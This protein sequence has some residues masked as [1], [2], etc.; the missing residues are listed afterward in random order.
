MDIGLLKNGILIRAAEC[1]ETFLYRR[2]DHIIVNSP[3]Y[4]Q[5]LEEKGVVSEKVTLVANGADPDFFAVNDVVARAAEVL[6][7]QWQ[8]HGKF[9]VVYTGA[10]RM[11]NQLDVL[12]DVAD[13]LQQR[14]VAA[15]LVVVGEGKERSRLEQIAEEKHLSNLLFVGSVSKEKMPAVLAAADAGFASLKPIRMFGMT[16]PNK[17]FDYMAAGKPVVLAIDGV[18]REVIESARAGIFA[19]CDDPDGIARVIEFL[20]EEPDV[21]S[22]MG[23]AGCEATR[24]RFNR[25]TQAKDFA[26]VFACLVEPATADDETQIDEAK[27]NSGH[28]VAA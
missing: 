22:M 28:Q 12:L 5:Y 9:V 21:A 11:A 25:A 4:T 19:P 2:A 8:S 1:L 20:V 10:I 26:D 3:A 16:Y 15:Q 13:L 23:K 18:I 6:R 27:A 17:V 7:E 14:S 24:Q